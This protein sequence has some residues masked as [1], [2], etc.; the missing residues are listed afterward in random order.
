M[1]IQIIK[2]K[3][4]IYYIFIIYLFI[5]LIYLYFNIWKKKKRNIYIYKI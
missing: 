3:I 2:K 4:Y 1:I 5:L